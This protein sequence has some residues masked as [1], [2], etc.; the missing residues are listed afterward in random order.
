[1]WAAVKAG[2]GAGTV[3]LIVGLQPVLTALWVAQHLAH[4]RRRPACGAPVARPRLGFA[5]IG[6]VVWR[7]LGGEVTP[8]NLAFAAVALVGITIGTLYQKRFVAPCDVR[9]ASAVQMLAGAR[10]LRCRWRCSSPSAFDWHPEPGRRDGLV[11]AA[12]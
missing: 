6:L 1:M 3:A 11:G 8:V 12:S 2:L 5:G 10:R 9:S 7:K 4:R